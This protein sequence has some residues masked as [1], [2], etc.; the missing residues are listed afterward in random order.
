MAPS[1]AH[2]SGRDYQVLAQLLFKREVIVMC[3]RHLQV[4]R[5]NREA[6]AAFRRESPGARAE[7]TE[8]L[9]QL[10]ECE[11][12]VQSVQGSRLHD[13]DPLKR[14]KLRVRQLKRKAIY[15]DDATQR[16]LLRATRA[17]VRNP[18]RA[19][20]REIRQRAAGEIDRQIRGI[21]IARLAHDCSEDLIVKDPV[22]TAK[23]RG[24]SGPKPLRRPRD[25]DPRREVIAIGIKNTC[26]IADESAKPRNQCESRIIESVFNAVAGFA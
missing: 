24:S 12:W 16:I 6:K 1:S 25:P 9:D 21:D 23:N 19:C 3:G 4:L 13:P 5:G 2:I 15:K 14:R 8:E 18:T 26:A 7:L 17:V 20:E 10:G 22:A 11:R